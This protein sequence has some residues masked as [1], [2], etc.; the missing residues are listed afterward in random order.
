MFKMS[1]L[2]EGATV[3]SA[4]FLLL[5]TVVTFFFS[6]NRQMMKRDH[7]QA[8]EQKNDEYNDL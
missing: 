4:V 5:T 7:R 1:K 6:V 2:S 8:L 3:V